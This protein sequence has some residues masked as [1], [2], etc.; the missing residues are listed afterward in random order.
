[1]GDAHPE[2]AVTEYQRA[3]ELSSPGAPDRG[4]IVEAYVTQLQALERYPECIT[5]AAREWAALSQ[6]TS[7]LNVVLAGLG[8]GSS[9][10]K[11]SSRGDE[12]GTLARRL[13]WQ[14]NLASPFSRMTAR[15]S[16]K[17]S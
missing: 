10:P 5:V 2:I 16:F 6:G 14:P 9:A 15:L 1:M 13:A 8:C 3:L 12:L 7:R 11:S 4:A 17:S